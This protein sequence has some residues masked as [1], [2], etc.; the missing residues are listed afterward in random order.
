LALLSPE[1]WALMSHKSFILV[2]A[3]SLTTLGYQGMAWAE[4]LI[5]NDRIQSCILSACGTPQVNRNGD[6]AFDN[7]QN[8]QS[9][10]AKAL[11]RVLEKDILKLADDQYSN[12]SKSAELLAKEIL[13]NE[14]LILS[15]SQ[16]MLF[17]FQKIGHGISGQAKKLLPYSAV[18][19]TVE[20]NP[21]ELD[22]YLATL[23]PDAR[24]ATTLILKKV[25]L[26]LFQEAYSTNQMESPLLARLKRLYPQ[27][28]TKEALIKD[29]KLLLGEHKRLVEWV[30][31]ELGKFVN[32]ESEI[33]ALRQAA[34]GKDLNSIQTAIYEKTAR[35]LGIYTKLMDPEVSR[36]LAKYPAEV[37]QDIKLL[38]ESKFVEK[39]MAQVREYT[40]LVAVKLASA[41]QANMRFSFDGNTSEIRIR[42]FQPVIAQVKAMA[43]IVVSKMADESTRA[44]L[45]KTIDDIQFSYPTTNAERLESIRAVLETEKLSVLKDQTELAASSRAIILLNALSDYFDPES[46]TLVQKINSK[47]PL[48]K[49][50]DG[51]PI[52]ATSDFAIS[53]LGKISI[54]WYTLAFP[55]RGATILAHEIG[56]VVSTKLRRGQLLNPQANKEFSKS[57]NC[58]ANR[59]PLTKEKVVLQGAQDSTWSE[60]D[61][62][63]H[64]SS[65]VME[66]FS[67]RGHLL[68]NAP[69]LGCTLVDNTAASYK[70]NKLEPAETSKHSTAFLR[71]LLTGLDRGQLNPEC[72]AIL[73]EVTPDR[74]LQCH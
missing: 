62:A 14:P 43:K 70:N 17:S 61:W 22:T 24:E 1:G 6:A 68:G 10:E 73:Q 25:F 38:R 52:S 48:A 2:M 12:A 19:E 59:N 67:K 21:Q 58:V 45:E 53:A 15:P 5:S 66:E 72:Q 34:E 65:L 3:M 30:G 57:L 60:E 26:P 56:H 11:S 13:N 51:L 55:D 31:E 40:P 7:I 74:T 44:E 54:S 27:L 50:C 41:C 69:N 20:I 71:L 32:D 4:G 16:Q 23:K 28:S 49:A 35:N 64:F 47:S 63:D 37:A 33:Q 46:E 9:R 29:G 18:L 42:K 8:I 36:A 39:K